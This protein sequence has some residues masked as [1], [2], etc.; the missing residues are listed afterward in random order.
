MRKQEKIGIK[1][2]I[3]NLILLF[4]I[5]SFSLPLSK[6]LIFFEITNK[7]WL[8]LDRNAFS[9]SIF[10][11]IISSG[12]KNLQETAI[13]TWIKDLTTET[14]S[15]AVF[16][17]QNESEPNIEGYKY[18]PLVPYFYTEKEVND[19]IEPIYE[20]KNYRLN[21]LMRLSSAKYF[22]YETD[23]EWFWSLNEECQVDHTNV[24]KIVDELDSKYDTGHDL[25]FQGHCMHYWDYFIQGGCGAIFSRLAA[26]R[27]L[28][29]GREWIEYIDED[30]EDVEFSHFREEIGLNINETQSPYMY[31]ISM[32]PTPKENWY[33]KW[34][35][36]CPDNPSNDKCSSSIY[37]IDQFSAYFTN[38]TEHRNTLINSMRKAREYDSSIHYYFNYNYI[39]FCRKGKRFGN[40]HIHHPND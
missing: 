8:T 5:I 16:F 34:I 12:D 26:K 24:N 35:P 27:F 19:I 22:L 21:A 39:H 13:S 37:Q 23:H 3:S 31:G 20:G 32:N 11:G 1:F 7:K 38:H 36:T 28:E 10:F 29:Y 30:P 18:I 25:V 4:S 17:I 6:D 15:E 14:K 40:R 33:K 9:K 2:N